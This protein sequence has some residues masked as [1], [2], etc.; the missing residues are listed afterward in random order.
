[1]RADNARSAFPFR[2]TRFWEDE[3]RVFNDVFKLTGINAVE[4]EYFNTRFSGLQPDDPRLYEWFLNVFCRLLEGEDYL[5][6]LD[7]VDSTLVTRSP[8]LLLENREFAVGRAI[9]VD[10]RKVSADLLFT[11]YDV[12]H[13]LELAPALLTDALIVA[14]LG[15]G[16]GRIGHM[17]CS[18]NPRLT[19][20]VFDIPDSLIV[21]SSYLP[22]VLPGCSVMS[23]REAREPARLERDTLQTRR[24]W[25]LGTHDLPRLADASVDLAVNVASFQEM[26]PDQVNRYLQVFG[27]LASRGC[28]YQRNNVLGPE[29]KRDDYVFPQGWTRM[30]EQTS[31]FSGV[32]F[33]SGWRIA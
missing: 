18:L 12:Y 33:E 23:Y 14:D 27:R 11:V 7:R 9:R 3:G 28:F 26:V 21:S 4:D 8:G 2:P 6:I 5:H 32:V 15:A 31:R 1:M 25:F 29:C 13:L 17:L 19:Y 30:F 24:L 16:W 20:V 10:G 22:T